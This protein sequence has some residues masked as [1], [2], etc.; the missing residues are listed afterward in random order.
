VPIH[1]TIAAVIPGL[2][3]FFPEGSTARTL[4]EAVPSGGQT[5]CMPGEFKDD[6]GICRSLGAGGQTGCPPGQFRDLQGNCRDLTEDITTPAEGAFPRGA[7]MHNGGPSGHTDTAPVTFNQ[8]V[9]RCNRWSVLGKDGW[10]HPKK[11]ISNKER[12]WPKPRK[13]LGTPGELNAVS[14][15]S[16]FAK[17]L[18]ANEK[19]LRGTAADF[20]KAS[21]YYRNRPGK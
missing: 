20:A 16:R 4:C 19:K 3:S 6:F 7:S 14:T 10:C 9:R 12:E 1:R 15:A 8:K 11:N 2:C 18:V 5:G 13:A 17:R 21:S